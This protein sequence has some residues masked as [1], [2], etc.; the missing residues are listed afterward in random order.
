MMTLRKRKGASMFQE[1]CDTKRGYKERKTALNVYFYGAQY[2]IR[3]LCVRLDVCVHMKWPYRGWNLQL[4]WLL[5]LQLPW[6]L[7]E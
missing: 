7:A 5:G 6:P 2:E 1:K 4:K 3:E